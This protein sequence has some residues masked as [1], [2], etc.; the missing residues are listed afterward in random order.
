MKSS[1]ICDFRNQIV[2]RLDADEPV[3]RLK[4]GGDRSS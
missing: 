1:K 4:A 2:D 3:K